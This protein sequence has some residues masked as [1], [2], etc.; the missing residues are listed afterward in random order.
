LQ[1]TM[2]ELKKKHHFNVD[3]KKRDSIFEKCTMCESL[4]DLISKLEN[5]NND[6]KEYELKL[7]KHLLHQESYKSLYHTWRF[8][9]MQSKDEFLLFIHNKMDHTKITF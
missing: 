2:S 3:V 9:F 4:K 1:S 7:K 5:N 6:A 8:E